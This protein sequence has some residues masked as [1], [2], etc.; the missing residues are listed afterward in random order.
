MLQLHGPSSLE[1]VHVAVGGKAGGVPEADRRLHAELSLTA[2]IALKVGALS[3]Q[4][5][6]LHVWCGERFSL[7]ACGLQYAPCLSRQLQMDSTKTM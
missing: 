2:F 6:V 7:G 3:F 4:N 5:L 1:G